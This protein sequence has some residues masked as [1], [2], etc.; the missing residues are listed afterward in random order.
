MGAARRQQDDHPRRLRHVLRPHPGQPDVLHDE[1]SAVSDQRVVQLR[2]ASTITGGCTTLAP[3]G[4]IQTIDP[5]RKTPYSE[6]F[7]LSIEREL[8]MRMIL[9]TSYVGTLRRHLLTEP[10]INIPYWTV[11]ANVA[12]TTNENSIRPYAGVSAIN[13][14]Q[15][16]AASNLPRAAGGGFTEH[17]GGTV[18]GSV[19]LWRRL[20]TAQSRPNGWLNRAVF[21]AARQS[22]RGTSGAG[23][24]QGPAL[25]QDNLSMTKFFQIHERTCGCARPRTH[26]NAV[27]IRVPF[28]AV[29]VFG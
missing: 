6:Q 26:T 23:N 22:R 28:V 7:S 18:H 19:H 9:Q 27:L 14:F 10:D 29:F 4:Q 25:Q 3:W 20:A 12:S 8:P 21:S 13:Q 1:Q 17:G 5:N 24:V 11:L 16:A 2:E 15:G